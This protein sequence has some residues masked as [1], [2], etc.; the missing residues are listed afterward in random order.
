ML[1]DHRKTIMVGRVRRC[2]NGTK[3][4]RR[5][6]IERIYFHLETTNKII[7]FD[8]D[9][10]LRKP[11][12]RAASLNRNIELAAGRGHISNAEDRDRP[13]PSEAAFFRFIH[14]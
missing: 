3:V 6:K 10:I 7:R 11:R 9:H 5:F 12:Y 13:T 2:L 1:I 4:S 14:G 8:S